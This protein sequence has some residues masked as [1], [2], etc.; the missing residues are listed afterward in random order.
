MAVPTLEELVAMREELSSLAAQRRT[1]GE[2]NDPTTQVSRDLINKRWAML[3]VEYS[4]KLRE[5][6]EAGHHEQVR[7]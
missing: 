6:I 4:M 2:A 7:P 1:F 5:F 3:D